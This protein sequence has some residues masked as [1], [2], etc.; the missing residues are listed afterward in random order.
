MLTD[1]YH[2]KLIFIKCLITYFNSFKM[3]K[4]RH[5]YSLWPKMKEACRPSE[6]CRICPE[7]KQLMAGMHYMTFKM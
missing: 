7:K 4:L 3:T 6:T 5:N 2:F 1:G